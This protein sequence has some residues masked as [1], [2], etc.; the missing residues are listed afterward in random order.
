MG[1]APPGQQPRPGVAAFGFGTEGHKAFKN[2]R[3][4]IKKGLES[5]LQGGGGSRALTLSLRLD[6]HVLA[7]PSAPLPG[8]LPSLPPPTSGCCRQRTAMTFPLPRRLAHRGPFTPSPSVWKKGPRLPRGLHRKCGAW[9]SGA[10]PQLLPRGAAPR[11]ALH[12]AGARR[13]AGREAEPCE[14]EGEGQ[15]LPVYV[16]TRPPRKGKGLESSL[17]LGGLQQETVCDS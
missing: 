10:S 8:L 15:A 17:L 11:W 6:G 3:L 4:E 14:G 12:R 2:K 1:S 7:M 9:R 5:W 13:R 16:T